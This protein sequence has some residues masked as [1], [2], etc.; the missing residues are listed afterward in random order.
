MHK[1]VQT[2]LQANC[3]NG[4]QPLAVAWH[5]LHHLLTHRALKPLHSFPCSIHRPVDL[6]ALT[7]HGML[8]LLLMLLL[9]SLGWT[10]FCRLTVR[11][12][13]DRH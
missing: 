3:P 9:Q 1:A 13:P 11:R 7:Q 2:A 8:L 6:L 4:I 12:N 5:R 10:S